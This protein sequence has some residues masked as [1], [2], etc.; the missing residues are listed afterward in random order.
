MEYQ[1]ESLGPTLRIVVFVCLDDLC[2]PG[3]GGCRLPCRVA[4][5]NREIAATIPRLLRSTSADGSGCQRESFGYWPWF[6]RS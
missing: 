2:T 3:I 4:G 5:T 6:G 1:F